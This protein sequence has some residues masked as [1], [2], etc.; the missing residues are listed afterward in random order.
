MH[1]IVNNTPDGFDTDHRDGDKLNNRRYNLRI[2]TRS[3]NSMNQKIRKNTSSEYKGV[4]YK[5][6]DKCWE[7]QIGINN[8][9]K[10]LGNYSSE[11]E[12]AKIYNKAALK[13]HGEFA[14]LNNLE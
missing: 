4:Y 1:R 8:C 6:R 12:A 11:I 2:A 7:A 14:R 13:Y 9:P 10:Y 3:Q 5:K